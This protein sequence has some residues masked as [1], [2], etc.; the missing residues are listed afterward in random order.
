MLSYRRL[1][2]E[3]PRLG[4]RRLILTHIGAESQVR[5]SEIEEEVAEDGLVL[6]L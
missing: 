4:C 5:L 6:A 2:G 1:A 3:R